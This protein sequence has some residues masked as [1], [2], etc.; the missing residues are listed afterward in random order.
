MLNAPVLNL[1]VGANTQMKSGT[2]FWGFG[3]LNVNLGNLNTDFRY[4]YFGYLKVYGNL[5]S[6][7]R[8]QDPGNVNFYLR[9][10][11]LYF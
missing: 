7:C 3:Y 11:H 8:N 6:D 1:G 10:L 2:L 4:L 9:Y 5:K